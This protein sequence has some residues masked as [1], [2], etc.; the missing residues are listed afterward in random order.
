MNTA[1]DNSEWHGAVDTGQVPDGDVVA[2]Q[3][4]GRDIALVRPGEELFAIDATGTQGATS[5][6]GGFL[7][8]DGSTL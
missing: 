8:S 5:L 6:C 3:V 4:V 1:G 7:K 2:A